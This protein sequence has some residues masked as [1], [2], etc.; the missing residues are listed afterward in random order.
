MA[1]TRTHI[2][3][4]RDTIAEIREH[5][6]NSHKIRAI[7]LLRAE[8]KI[9]E[10]GEIRSPGLREAKHAIDAVIDPTLLS[11]AEA[12]IA[13]AWRVNTLKISGPDRMAVSYT[14]LT[15]PTKA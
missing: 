9:R 5:I 11:T 6:N 1:G 13:P 10:D 4:H 7:K 2:F 8:G 15:L 12:V 14:H 3:V